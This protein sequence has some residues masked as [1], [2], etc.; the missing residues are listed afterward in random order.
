MAAP[1]SHDPYATLG[2]DKDA[3]SS[4]VKT[5]YRKLALTC[6]PDKVLDPQLKAEKTDQ[7]H[8]IQE[9][10]DILIDDDKRRKH[11]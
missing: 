1:L 6:H 9:A 10:Y 2:I 3:P 5:A 7:F 11:D 4:A 8:K